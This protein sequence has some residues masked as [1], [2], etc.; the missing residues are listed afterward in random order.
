M[1]RIA[2]FF[3]FLLVLASGCAVIPGND[4]AKMRATKQSSIPLPVE[5]PDGEVPAYIQIQPITADL[6]I[7]QE[8]GFFPD[9]SVS[10]EPPAHQDYRLGAGDVVNVIVWD[11][12]EL[13]MPAGEFRSA[14]Q[15]GSVVSEAGTIYF[16][17]AGVVQAAGLTVNELRD[18]LTGL[19][20]STIENVQLE[21]RVAAYRSQRI[22]VVGEVQK[23]GIVPI[24]DVAMTVIEAINLAGGFGESADQK[25][26]VLTRG[27]NTRRVDL[28]ALY[29]H[30]DTS[31]N[32]LLRHGDI[33]SVPDRGYNKI[34]VLGAV[35]RPGSKPMGRHRVTLAEAL[36]DAQ[37]VQQYAANPHQIY[38]LRGGDQPAIYH[39][40]SKSPDALLLADRFILK[41]RDVVYVDAASIIRWNRLVSNILP[42]T[43][44]LNSV[45]GLGFRYGAE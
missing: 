35:N 23:P 18:K 37:D 15:S 21:V 38:V 4:V 32:L 22:Y 24:T 42:T 14:E 31:Q 45:E 6:V 33:L 17:Y 11:H 36:G 9:A 13:T 8:R 29:E 28:Q 26:V 3:L 30:G 7:H 12:P 2:I 27:G 41:P 19:L 10:R 39:L 1:Y 43:N 20:S 40:A 16:P 5:T 44:V 34:F 25:N